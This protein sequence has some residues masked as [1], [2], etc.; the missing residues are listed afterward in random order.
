[1]EPAHGD[2][3]NDVM[4][5]RLTDGLLSK[6]IYLEL[7]INILLDITFTWVFFIIQL[8]GLSQYGQGETL[9]ILYQDQGT[10]VVHGT[11]HR[12]I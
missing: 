10:P 3:Q 12:K 7:G 11:P 1:M 4:K 5:F 9:C 8:N 2:L 6:E